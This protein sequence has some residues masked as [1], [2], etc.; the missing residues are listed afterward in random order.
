[1]VSSHAEGWADLALEAGMAQGAHNVG[2]VQVLGYGHLHGGPIWGA[3]DVL[4]LLR[5]YD[6]QPQACTVH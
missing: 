3:L 6:L 2:V 5:C 1:M 4:V